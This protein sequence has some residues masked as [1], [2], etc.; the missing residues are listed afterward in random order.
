ME[1]EGLPHVY[2]CVWKQIHQYSKSTSSIPQSTLQ[3]YFKYTSEFDNK[4]INFGSLLQVQ[5]WVR[6][7][8]DKLR[9]PTLSIL[10][11]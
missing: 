10:M 8:I 6:K 7:Q 2:F 1:L 4:C 3:V 9:K 5:L 11:N